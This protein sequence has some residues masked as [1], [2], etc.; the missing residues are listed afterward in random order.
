LGPLTSATSGDTDTS[1]SLFISNWD[2][3][4]WCEISRDV[5][6]DFRTMFS[7]AAVGSIFS[8]GQATVT[9][10]LELLGYGVIPS[11]Q[12]IFWD[13]V[14]SIA[15][16][17]APTTNSSTIT[18]M[19]STSVLTP[20][21][22]QTSA[23]EVE[24]QSTLANPEPTTNTATISSMGNGTFLVPYAG[25]LLI[26]II[27]I[28]AVAFMVL[29]KKPNV[30]SHLEREFGKQYC[31]NCGSKLPQNARYCGECGSSQAE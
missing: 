26:G 15:Q 18:T 14:Q 17:P 20:T 1:K 24:T 12:F 25:E 30:P 22:N 2:C 9:V 19:I 4:S 23:G 21:N 3:I 28:I 31:T 8:S 13:D 29:H 10:A 7:T 16:I 27:A 5:G 11:S 6:L